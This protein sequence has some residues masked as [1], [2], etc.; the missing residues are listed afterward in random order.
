MKRKKSEVP[1]WPF[2]RL[3]AD[4]YCYSEFVISKMVFSGLNIS[5]PVTGVH[6]KRKNQRFPICRF[7]DSK[8][9]IIATVSLNFEN[10]VL[11]LKFLL[12]E[13][14]LFWIRLHPATLTSSSGG[15]I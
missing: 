12:Q 15:I 4:H 5:L 1:N 9:I 2:W 11:G 7:G 13:K 8:L 3:K 10:G 6:T 14:E